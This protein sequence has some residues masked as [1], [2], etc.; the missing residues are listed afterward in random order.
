MLEVKRLFLGFMED[1]KDFLG[2][3]LFQRFSPAAKILVEANGGILH[4]FVCFLG[5]A[6]E[7]EVL[8]VRQPPMPILVIQPQANKAHDLSIFSAVLAWHRVAPR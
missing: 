6:D 2:R 3:R 4:A 1:F 8:A 5:A 7:K